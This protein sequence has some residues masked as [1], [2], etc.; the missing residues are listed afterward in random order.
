MRT[1]RTAALPLLLLV[2]C[3]GSSEPAGANSAGANAGVEAQPAPGGQPFQVT[4][5]GQFNAPWAMAF[6]PGS[7][8]AQTSRA[9][10]TEKG[11]K[12]ILVDVASGQRQEVSGVP[13]NIRVAGQGGLGD[14]MPAPDFAA[15]QRVYLSFVEPGAGGSGAALGY[16]R[17]VIGSGAPRLDGFKVIWRQDP[18]VSGNGHFSHRIAF[19]PDGSIYLS[20]GE[21]QKMQPAQDRSSDLGKV[22]HMDA[23]GKRIGGRFHSMGHRNV[24][25]LAFT[26]DGRLW[27]SEMGPQGGDEINLVEQGRNYGWPL[28]SNG[29]HYGGEEIPDHPTRPEFAAPKV[30]WNPSISPAGMIV[31]SGDLFPQ[32]KGDI[33][34]GALSGQAL[35]RADVDGADA[36]KGDQWDM[37]ARIREVEQGPRGEVY[38]LEDGPGGRLLRLEPAQTRR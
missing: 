25:G 21:R 2:G 31:Y 15:S 12:L 3:T 20:S 14:V 16:G 35:I 34:L 26:P 23:E 1:L 18:K 36:R 11:G 29:S 30:W 6:L 27:A 38:L 17:L 9:L 19:A 33:L 8:A 13:T 4:P 5:L 37:G 24:L 10:V 22:I 7:G 32:W 28:V